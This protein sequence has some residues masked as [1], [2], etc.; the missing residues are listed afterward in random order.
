[1]R[2]SGQVRSVYDHTGE[3]TRVRLLDADSDAI[4]IKGLWLTFDS[5]RSILETLKQGDTIFAVGQIKSVS[6]F[7]V[8]YHNCELIKAE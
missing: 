5:D 7:D 6:I 1:M 4:G 3:R 2:I 8:E